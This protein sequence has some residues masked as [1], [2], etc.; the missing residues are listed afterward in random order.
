[1][2]DLHDVSY[3]KR[4]PEKLQTPYSDVGQ[5][6]NALCAR[7]TSTYL[8]SGLKKRRWLQFQN[9]RHRQ[10]ASNEMLAMDIHNTGCGTCGPAGV[11][12]GMAFTPI[13]C[14]N[15]SR[16]IIQYMLLVFL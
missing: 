1:V 16:G 9:L 8:V 12:P 15:N 14:K 5:V 4:T 10:F 7:G 3:D 13:P 2:S 11:H 6:R